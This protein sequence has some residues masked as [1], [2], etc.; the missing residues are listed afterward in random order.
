MG[1]K[2]LLKKKKNVQSKKNDLDFYSMKSNI[3]S[4]LID[5]YNPEPKFNERG[6]LIKNNS[7]LDYAI[8]YNYYI[9]NEFNSKC[10]SL[11]VDYIN[12]T[13]LK[14]KFKTENNFITKFIKVIK[15]LMMNE[16]EL[17]LFFLYLDK[18]TC[19]KITKFSDLYF[20]GYATKI[21]ANKETKIIKKKLN[22]LFDNFNRQYDFFIIEF[23]KEFE[24][25]F[26]FIEI[27][28]QI[29]KLNK[30]H[31]NYCK[32]NYIDYNGVVDKIINLCQPYKGDSRGIQLKTKKIKEVNSIIDSDINKTT[33]AVNNSVIKTDPNNNGLNLINSCN[34]G[35]Y[36]Y[37]ENDLTNS[38]TNYNNN[39]INNLIRKNISRNNSIIINDN[40]INNNLNDNL[41]FKSFSNEMKK[42]E[43]FLSPQISNVFN[44][45][46][47]LNDSVTFFKR[48]SSI[49]SDKKNKDY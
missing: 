13:N 19:E 47:N 1:K 27:N 12:Q 43:G 4:E 23:G 25:N 34:I 46:S 31:N 40:N 30:P 9:S 24:Y 22:E 17:I 18:I 3:L 29:K 7:K 16:F 8:A 32:Q 38:L 48:N 6:S 28:E 42:N 20:I 45:N 44:K 41:L 26:D 14:K 35:N 11:C 39:I 2:N 21:K 33:Y 49:F 37:G 15:D 36:Y 10:V 5:S